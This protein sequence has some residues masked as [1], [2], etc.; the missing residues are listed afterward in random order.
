M[1]REIINCYKKNGKATILPLMVYTIL[2][3][4]LVLIYAITWILKP[5]EPINMNE[6]ESLN[7]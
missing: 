1:K 4:P 5:I 7:F 6:L 2:S 3:G